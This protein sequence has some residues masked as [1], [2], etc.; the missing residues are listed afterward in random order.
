[1]LGVYPGISE[2]VALSRVLKVFFL[3][4]AHLLLLLLLA[5]YYRTIF[6]GHKT[7]PE[8]FYLSDDQLD[9][10]DQCVSIRK[11]FILWSAQTVL[12]YVV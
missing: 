5:S 6:T 8:C 7:I 10:L 4:F 12:W 11:I 1:M 3:L 9:E 2:S